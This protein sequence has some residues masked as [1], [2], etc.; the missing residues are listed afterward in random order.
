MFDLSLRPICGVH[1]VE[2]YIMSRSKVA[3]LSFLQKAKAQFIL[4]N[5][6]TTRI[7]RNTI[8]GISLIHNIDP[9]V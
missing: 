4:C 5:I 6:A 2:I 7:L 8:P 3:L 1:M 9:D